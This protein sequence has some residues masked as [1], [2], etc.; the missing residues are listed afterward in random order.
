MTTFIYLVYI[1]VCLF[2]ISV[3][4][5]QPGKLGG[6]LG[7]IGGGGGGNTVFGARGATTFLQKFTVGMAA[8]FM[9][10]SLLLAYMSTSHSITSDED[11]RP[12]R[13][14]APLPTVESPTPAPTPQ[15]IEI[16]PS[17]APSDDGA[18][19]PTPSQPDAAP[20][21]G[22]PAPTDEAPAPAEGTTA[23]TEGTTAP[24]EGAPAE[25]APAPTP[26]EGG[27]TAPA[28][29]EGAPFNP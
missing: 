16:V 13:G 19:A 9:L 14:A 18:A 20:A 24:P 25:E 29:A 11:E 17:T 7:A 21:E 12:S 8:T 22:T 3:V 26:A 5:L 6:G 2:L 15:P 1:F 28:P 4:L 23:P 10:L 27:E